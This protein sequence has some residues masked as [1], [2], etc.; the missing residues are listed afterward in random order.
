[1][2]LFGFGRKTLGYDYQRCKHLVLY[3][4]NMFESLRVK[5]VGHIMEAMEE[6]GKLTYIDVRA[7][8]TAMK[9]T[10]FW[11]VRPGTDYALNLG[12]IHA[13]LRDKLYDA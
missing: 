11:M 7:S 12:I 2:S 10:R 8:G 13:I 3:G 5:A 4:R 1:M 9:A 6:G